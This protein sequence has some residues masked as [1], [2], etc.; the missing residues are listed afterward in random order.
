MKEIENFDDESN[1]SAEVDG[2]EL[3]G[4][5]G[6]PADEPAKLAKP[7]SDDDD[8]VA[9]P[10]PEPTG[11]VLAAPTLDPSALYWA[12]IQRVPLLEAGEELRLAQSWREHGDRA[13]RDKLVNSHLRMVHKIARDLKKRCPKHFRLEGLIGEGNLAL[14]NA[15][16]LFDPSQGYRFSTYAR[17]AIT[18]AI[19]SYI[20]RSASIVKIGTK[21]ENPWW[22]SRDKSLNAPIY[23]GNGEPAGELQDQLLDDVSDQ[24]ARL[25]AAE[26]LSDYDEA[27]D[28]LLDKRELRI[29]KA[30]RLTDEPIPR[31]ELAREFGV[32][33]E[34]IRQIEVDAFKKLQEALNSGAFKPARAARHF[35]GN[36][37]PLKVADAAKPAHGRLVDGVTLEWHKRLKHCE[38]WSAWRD[39][40][41]LQDC[42]VALRSPSEGRDRRRVKELKQAARGAASHVIDIAGEEYVVPIMQARVPRIAAWPGPPRARKRKYQRVELRPPAGHPN[43]LMLPVRR[44]RLDKDRDDLPAPID[45]ARGLASVG[46]RLPPPSISKAAWHEQQLAEEKEGIY[47]PAWD[48]QKRVWEKEGRQTTKWPTILPVKRVFTRDKIAEQQAEASVHTNLLHLSPRP[49]PKHHWRN[50]WQGVWPRYTERTGLYK[51]TEAD[52]YAA[53]AALR[54]EAEELVAVFFKRGGTVTR[55]T[56]FLKSDGTVVAPEG[57]YVPHP[58]SDCGV[59]VHKICE[60]Y[61]VHDELWD[62]AHKHAPR[63]ARGF[64]CVSCLEGR[65]GRELTPADFTDALC[66]NPKIAGNVMSPH[67]RAR[68]GAPSWWHAIFSK[69]LPDNAQGFALAAE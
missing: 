42:S 36:A 46:F 40:R 59:D 2:P 7:T 13:A 68:V 39:G 37:S 25:A 58:C 28:A 63:K 24:E 15:A 55:V 66:N 61:K 53:K 22:H 3:T 26:T 8:T 52:R 54:R 38:G 17:A 29:L 64:L 56:A 47:E 60:W 69:F 45:N 65:I 10:V 5:D 31:E 62:R 43:Y 57:E 21:D 33:P 14:V 16:K 30:R 12:E 23:D 6:D 48:E 27:A 11:T 49:L 1:S 20:Q 35:G 41:W 50:K 34:Y 19:N 18:N 51:D 4:D 32:T 9:P 44:R 67:L